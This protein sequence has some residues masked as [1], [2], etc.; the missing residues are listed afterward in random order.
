MKIGYARVSTTDQ[1]LNPQTDPLSEAGCEKLFTDVAQR[2]K[3]PT[4]K[5]G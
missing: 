4:P 1:S 3:D 5:P 2:G